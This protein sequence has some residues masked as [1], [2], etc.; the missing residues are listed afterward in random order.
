M[1]TR[2][3]RKCAV[4]C[5]EDSL[6]GEEDAESG[7]C[8]RRVFAFIMLCPSEKVTV[9]GVNLQH[10]LDR[11]NYAMA[12]GRFQQND[13]IIGDSPSYTL[14]SLVFLN[15]SKE[16]NRQKN[17]TILPRFHGASSTLL[18]AS[19]NSLCALG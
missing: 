13:V 5:R 15:G 6:E 17:W 2:L 16:R 8:H 3:D 9:S 14:P 10:K 4:F 12:T 19:Q 7:R 18:F 11:W 1:L